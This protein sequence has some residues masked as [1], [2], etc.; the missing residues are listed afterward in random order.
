MEPIT[1]ILGTIG[2]LLG[3]FSKISDVYKQHEIKKNIEDLVYAYAKN[4]CEKNKFNKEK[5]KQVIAYAILIARN[6][7]YQNNF[8]YENWIDGKIDIDIEDES[9]F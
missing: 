3:S 5:T 4:Y 9:H 8:K 7:Y 1:I 6:Q 2:T